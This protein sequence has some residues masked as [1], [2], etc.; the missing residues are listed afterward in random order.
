VDALGID[1]KH[2]S[3]NG[4]IGLALGARGAG[5][6][7]AHYEPGRHA[8]NIT[9]VRGGGSYAHEWGHALDDVIARHYLPDTGQAGAMGFTNRPDSQHFP[10]D[11]RDAVARVMDAMNK[12]ADPAAAQA[13]HKAELA[14]LDG[15]VRSTL[16]E[17][18][19][20]MA[21]VSKAKALPTDEAHRERKAQV[22]DRM[23]AFERQR[24]EDLEARAATAPPKTKAKMLGEARD[25]RY[26]EKVAVERAAA[27]RASPVATEADAARLK[28]LE[29]EAEKLRTTHNDVVKKYNDHRKVGPN[30]SEFRMNSKGAYL[31]S[32]HEM[33]ARAFES[34][35]ADEL[36][37]KGRRNTYLVDHINKIGDEYPKGEERKNINGAM[38]NLV[39]V[40]TK[41]GHLAKAMA[42]PLFKG[43]PNGSIES[44]GLDT[45]SP[46]PGVVL[47]PRAHR[48]PFPFAGYMDFRGLP[49]H[50]EN[51]R[52][53]VRQGVD[54]SGK[55]WSV[56]MAHH[57]GEIE[58]TEGADGDPLDVYVG[59]DVGSDVVVVVR[60]V[61]PDTRA[62]DE[63]KAMLGFASVNAALRAYRDQ[64]N[65]PGFYGGHTT[66]TLDALPAWIAKNA[67]KAEAPTDEPTLGNL[68]AALL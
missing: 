21:E 43:T 46:A 6:A 57:Y 58:S 5:K 10:K 20:K 36:E 25:A 9:K 49:I 42:G 65:R 28:A 12:P 51:L 41:G 52:G 60:Q 68:T 15:E 2:A 34:F 62:F 26:R 22:A 67:N 33:F 13:K 63:H 11:V 16:E 7:A 47:P 48:D 37:A 38:R 29:G 35:V 59:P 64:Y 23:A 66:M 55:P 56:T 32:N 50:L 31:G 30:T 40:L 24:A 39:D 1:P 27:H 18:N 61:D 17:Y 44:P 4:R 53:S 14:R 45:V 54:P 19:D 8:I 3:F